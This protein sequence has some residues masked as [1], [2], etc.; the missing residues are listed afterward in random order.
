MQDYHPIAYISRSSGPKW[1]KLS[2]Y[3]KE[4]LAIVFAVQK[5]EP[6]LMSSHFIIKTDQKILKWLLLQK[7]STPFQQFWLP[8]LMGFNYKIQYKFG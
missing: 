1:K 2:V 4:W 7:V 3:E 6:Y 8:K 5:W